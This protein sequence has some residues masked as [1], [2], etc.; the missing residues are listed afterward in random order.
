M[1]VYNYLFYHNN[2]DNTVTI[3]L[4]RI[5]SPLLTNFPIAI[6]AI[7]VTMVTLVT[8]IPMCILVTL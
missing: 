7:L 2:P 1:Y 4:W 8:I 3:Y 5:W 6:M